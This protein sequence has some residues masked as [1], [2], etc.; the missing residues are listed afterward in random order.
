VRLGL[1]GI[2]RGAVVDTSF[3]T[4]NYP[5]RFSLEDAIWGIPRL[6]RMKR[7]SCKLPPRIGK[8]LQE[9]A[10]KG[11]SQNS[12]AVSHAG[13][14]THVRFKIYPDGG[15]ARLRLYGEV[16]PN[17]AG[18]AKRELDLAAVEMAGGDFHQRSILQRAAQHA[19]ARTQQKYER[20]VGN[21]A[22]T[23]AGARLAIVKLGMPG[24]IH[25]VEVE[26][27]AL[28]GKFSG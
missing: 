20:R 8:D 15:V 27:D 26:Y 23:R 13:R 17:A 12:A 6:I 10:L 24:T 5:A 16:V 14:F 22:Q 2:L 1:P 7:K 4:G 9:T 28:Q 19:D 11:D 18:I 25:R 3:F 21:A